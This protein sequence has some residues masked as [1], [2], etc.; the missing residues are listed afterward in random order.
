MKRRHQVVLFAVLLLSL[1]IL[2]PSFDF[3]GVPQNQDQDQE[4]D[5]FPNAV[6]R[7]ENQQAP[8]EIVVSMSE[9]EF[10]VFSAI[11]KQV[12]AARVVKINLRNL[13]SDTYKEVLDNE[14]AVGT[15]GILSCLIVRKFR[16]M[17][18]EGICTL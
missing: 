17:P 15:A 6:T 18:K 11:A 14:L 8:V 3:R 10:Q 16:V 4:N 5:A 1:T 13:A 9:S 12:A 7:S 2:S